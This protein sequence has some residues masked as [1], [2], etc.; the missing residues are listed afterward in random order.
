VTGTGAAATPVTG[1]KLGAGF[2]LGEPS[3]RAAWG[4]HD[5]ARPLDCTV[6]A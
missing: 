3:W 1:F 5:S 2:L 4:G 6:L